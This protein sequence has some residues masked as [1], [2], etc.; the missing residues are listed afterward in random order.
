M[1]KISKT[2]V[3]TLAAKFD[4]NKQVKLQ[5]RVGGKTLDETADEVL[6]QARQ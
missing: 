4:N 6:K 5:G 2:D 3:D 1:L